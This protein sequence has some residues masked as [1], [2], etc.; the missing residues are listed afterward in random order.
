VNRGDIRFYVFKPPDK[1][2]LVLIL[3]RDSVIPYLGEVTVAPLTSTIRGMPSEVLLTREDG[4]PQDCVVNLDHIQTVPKEKLGKLIGG[5]SS[6]KMA[7]IKMAILF[8]LG[9]DS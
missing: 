9:F 3:T 4:S 8:A 2:R 5:L 7:T 1:K 6:A